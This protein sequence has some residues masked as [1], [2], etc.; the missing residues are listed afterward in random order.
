MALLSA[1]KEIERQDEIDRS[2][3]EGSS[4]WTTSAIA[5]PNR[6]PSA[7]EIFNVEHDL[8]RKTLKR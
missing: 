8:K 1:P 7:I 2:D 3:S 4:E 5:N 6:D